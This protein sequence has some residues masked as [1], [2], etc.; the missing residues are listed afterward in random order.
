[1]VDHQPSSREQQAAEE[2]GQTEITRAQARTLT[3]AFCVLIFVVPAVQHVAELRGISSGAISDRTWP[4]AYDV[5]HM[6]PMPS[7]KQIQQFEDQLEEQSIVRQQVQPRVQYML[8]RLFGVGNE[9]AY[10]GRDNWL[11]LKAGID[12]VTAPPFLAD[13]HLSSTL[14][15]AT[16]RNRSPIP[17]IVKFKE[18]LAREDIA[19]VVMPTPVKPVVYPEMFSNRFRASDQPVHNAAFADFR[20]QLEDKGI[21]VIDVAPALVAAKG[22]GDGPLYL[23]ADTHWTPRGMQIAAEQ[24]AKLIEQ[25]DLGLT[26]AGHIEQTR[27]EEAVSNR[28]DVAAMLGFPVETEL[29]ANEQ[30]TIQPITET[31]STNGASASHSEILF[32]GDSFSN[33]YSDPQLGWGAQA[34]LIE[35]LSYRLGRKID[36]IIRNGDGA[37]ATRQD[38]IRQLSDAQHPAEQ[39]LESASRSP[40]EGKKLVIYQ[41]AIRELAV[42]DWKPLELPRSTGSPPPPHHTHTI[43]PGELLVEGTIADIAGVP[44]PGTVPY[45]D[46][47]TSVHLTDLNILEGSFDAPAEG[48]VVFVWGMRDNKWTKAASY[49]SGQKITL[50]LKPWQSVRETHGRHVRIELDDEMGEL[51]LLDSFWGEPAR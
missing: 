46:A 47:I 49:R 11:F 16:E 48:I 50:K 27:G 45:R 19:L 43:E 42:G 5:F 2:V 8:S 35:Q 36:R 26:D 13:N 33:I 37:F 9:R 28:G 7:Q 40:L 38:L 12:Y 17:A 24:L 14:A 10:V 21:P 6:L 23:R 32:L 22:N 20:Q 39:Q 18:D 15:T 4:Q 25:S 41:F 30:V 51:L 3:V 29:G 44:R 1:M 34:G 31:D